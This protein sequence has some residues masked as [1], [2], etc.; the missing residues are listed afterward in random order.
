M[1]SYN[2]VLGYQDNLNKA[3]EYLDNNNVL[4]AL[5]L[6]NP[7][8]KL[9]NVYK[10]KTGTWGDN[11][12]YVLVGKITAKNEILF[13]EP[14]KSTVDL[15]SLSTYYPYWMVE[16]KEGKLNINNLISHLE[17]PEFNDL[18]QIRYPI[19]G[20]ILSYDTDAFVLGYAGGSYDKAQV[21]FYDQ[22]L[23]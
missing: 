6:L 13:N 11:A 14:K 8:E 1:L 17:V 2:Y 20:S 12:E 10:H 21:V 19:G 5:E 4:D 7:V 16:D 23:D 22:Y 18:V 15:N 9:R 3:V